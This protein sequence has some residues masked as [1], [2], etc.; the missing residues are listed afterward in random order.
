MDTVVESVVVDPINK[1]NDI[2]MT[3]DYTTCIRCNRLI[4]VRRTV[5][6]DCEY[7]HIMWIRDNN[8]PANDH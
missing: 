2:Y 4:P 3:S 1:L 6:F 8:E 5:C 7:D